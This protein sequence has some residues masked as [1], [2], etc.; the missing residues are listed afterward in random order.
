VGGEKEKVQVRGGAGRCP[1]CHDLI[2]DP[3]QVV[4]CAACGARQH[5]QCYDQHGAC[6][7]C[8]STDVLVPRTRARTQASERPPRGSKI[9]IEE[10]SGDTV[11]GWE[12]AVG[13]HLGLLIFLCAIMVVTI[14]LVP[15]LL[16]FWLKKRNAS[17]KLVLHE[18]GLA[19]TTDGPLQKRK[20][21][22]ARREEVGAIRLDRIQQTA[23]LRL[24]L[25]VGVDRLVVATAGP[26]TMAP[27]KE[28]EVEWLYQQLLAWKEGA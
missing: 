11:Y 27:L 8:S 22:V 7:A 17:S 26:G 3:K 14:P 20:H 9:K 5:E 13:Q 2:S 28:P 19:L 18:N 16:Y 10:R 12:T 4:A 1:F 6:S 25:D 21:V 24:T 23:S 15:V